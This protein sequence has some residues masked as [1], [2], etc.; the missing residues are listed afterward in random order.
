MKTSLEFITDNLHNDLHLEEIASVIRLSPF[1]FARLFKAATGQSPYQYLLS[2]RLRRAKDF[3][4]SSSLPI[5]EIAAQ[6]GFPNHAHFSR[7]FRKREKECR[8]MSGD[9]YNGAE[10][11]NVGRPLIMPA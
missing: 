7:A 9:R 11:T 10:S 8:L 3:L 1:H 4:R 5:A 6:V 2:Q